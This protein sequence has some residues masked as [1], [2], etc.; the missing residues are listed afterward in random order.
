MAKRA[1]S[2]VTAKRAGG[3]VMHGGQAGWP[4]LLAVDGGASKTE[5]VL[6][7]AD[8]SL[9]GRAL[10]AASNH[11]IVGL[12]GAM[13][14]IGATIHAAIADAGL[15]SKMG[16]ASVG[17]S[18]GASDGASDGAPACALG[19]YCLAGLDLGTDED[20]LATAVRLRGWS[21]HDLLYNDTFAV[22]RSGVR[23]RWGV[24]VVCGTGLNCVGLGPDGTTVRFPALGELSGDFAPGG[25]WLGIRGLGLALRAG[26]G[27]GGPT[28]LRRLVAEHFD[29][30]SPEAV[31][32]AVYTGTVQM[33]RL[34]ELA[35]VVLGAAGRG[36]E[37]ARGAVDGLVTEVVAMAVAAIESLEGRG[38]TSSTD[39]RTSSAPPGLDVVVGGGL[40][41]D[42]RFTES[43]REG[44]RRRVPGAVLRG[45]TGPPV[46]GAALLGLDHLG[47]GSSVEDRLRSQLV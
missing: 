4:V 3:G 1:G 34:A 14:T 42:P 29:L 32:E 26:D 21:T 27:R 7:A 25:I 18:E 15:T 30:T 47:G 11:Q 19:V 23:S 38:A 36:D 5:V 31:L 22:L 8:G 44:I 9:V 16:S 10:G 17:A 37:Q 13:D 40:F 46:L 2:G 6:V 35:Q 20:R 28:E 43:V 33:G 24:G 12:D 39:P 45:I 41:S